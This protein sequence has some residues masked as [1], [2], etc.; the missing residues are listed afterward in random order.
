VRTVA[1]A[2]HRRPSADRQAELAI[3]RYAIP[4]D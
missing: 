4:P 2:E 1:S 3:N